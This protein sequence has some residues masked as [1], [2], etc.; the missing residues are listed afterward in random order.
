[1]AEGKFVISAQNRIKEG[2]DAAKHDLAGFE[3][4][5]KKI[6][7]TLKSAFAVTAI[8][9][10]LEKLGKAT[11]DCYQEF[12]EGDRRL[13]QLKIALNDND[14]SLAKATHLI[15]EMRTMS[16]ASKD[17]IEELVTELA[18]LGKSDK[19]I[20]KITRA[21]VNLSN[22]TGKDLNTSF[23]QINATYAGT[24]GKLEK[25]LPELGSLTDKQLTAGGAADIINN[26]FTE[27]STNLAENNIPQKLKNLGDG[28]KQLKENAGEKS[29]SFF[30]PIIDAIQSV[31]DKWNDAYTAQKNYFLLGTQ[32]NYVAKITAAKENIDIFKPQLDAFDKQILDRNT[33]YDKMKKQD[34]DSAS[35]RMWNDAT[36]V[37]VAERNKLKLK[38]D[39]LEA[40]ITDWKKLI[41]SSPTTFDK[42]FNLAKFGK[43]GE[44]DNYTGGK[45]L[46]DAELMTK[47]AP[48]SSMA[49]Y[50]FAR[51]F[52]E[53]FEKGMFEPLKLSPSQESDQSAAVQYGKEYRDAFQKF[54]A[55][56]TLGQIITKQLN[57]NNKI[58]RVLSPTGVL[59]DLL[60]GVSA[61]TTTP[62]KMGDKQTFGQ[63][64]LIPASS[65]K[66]SSD[67]YEQ[68][69]SDLV[70]P[71]SLEAAQ[72]GAMAF[73]KAYRDGLSA[74]N[75][76]QDVANTLERM[77]NDALD[78]LAADYKTKPG[79]MGQSGLKPEGY[80]D[81]PS[82][83]DQIGE[84]FPSVLDQ[85]T[86]GMTGAFDTVTASMGGFDA[87]MISP[88]TT[89][90]EAL[91]PFGDMIAGMNPLLAILIP[92]I[93]GFV[94]VIGPAI[95]EVLDPLFNA[96]TQIGQ[97]L[98]A[99]LL[100]IL[101]A[102]API[103]SL[104]ANIL[105]T[106]FTPVLQIL[107]P[108]IQIVAL[109][110]QMMSPVLVLLAKAFT[111]LMAP[112]QFIADL[113]SWL[114]G[115]I[116]TFAW[117]IAH[118]FRQRGYEGFS[119]DAFSGLADRL[120]AIDA[121]GT[122]SQSISSSYS[123]SDATATQS[124]SYRTQPIILN[125]YQQAPVVGSDGMSEFARMIRGEIE[126]LAYAGA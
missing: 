73:G 116:E 126:L 45:P 47:F 117:N 18:S 80:V 110:F 20:D 109:M 51:Q 90:M 82:I 74:W 25:L 106:A 7:D 13:K 56:E 96:L 122:N 93:M 87:A 107:A 48:N 6:G 121:I 113:F 40:S 46:T 63:S 67:F 57:E 24:S 71:A 37:I 88:I 14:I 4:E 55:G 84:L 81:K 8:I 33:K 70:I 104:V 114:G 89:I 72:D 44:S 85:I 119:S 54:T 35:L 105:M 120:A 30:S 94:S 78:Q 10:S 95:T 28:F 52:Y 53:Q 19:E 39:T 112:V 29:A 68:L 27:L 2:L 49:K 108:V 61:P 103:I 23:T 11:F 41:S 21:S 36:D 124:A 31:I 111:I 1:M 64:G 76:A 42:T 77:W 125:I 115:I 32:G 9:A 66:W 17:D 100:P 91:G 43:Q 34:V 92:I 62:W 16:L 101:D 102:I 75:A 12:G 83:T 5:T 99:A 22:I 86:V 118:P 69:V 59:A 38:I 65:S 60:K 97:M 50:I 79:K 26:K 3:Q 58:S 123:Q 98:G 15:D